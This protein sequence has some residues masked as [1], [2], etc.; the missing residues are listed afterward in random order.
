MKEN[1][2][3]KIHQGRNIK[4][5]RQAK[6]MKQEFFAEKIEV[7]Q[8]VVTKIEKQSIIDD[9]LLSKCADALGISVEL[10]KNFDPETM[11]DHHIFYYEDINFP[12]KAISSSKGVSNSSFFHFAIER[13][14][15]M[16]KK[17]IELYERLLQAE[18]DKNALLEKMLGL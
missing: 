11:F 6:N 7:S 15:E 9:A 12:D 17:N 14:M 10:I 5:F 1:N 13:M 18:K 2:K 4:F 8:P 16:H 3:V